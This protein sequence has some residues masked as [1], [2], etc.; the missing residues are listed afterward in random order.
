[1]TIGESIMALGLVYET[2]NILQCRILGSE[3]GGYE[4]YYLLGYNAV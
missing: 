2:M 1:M 4:K 3:S